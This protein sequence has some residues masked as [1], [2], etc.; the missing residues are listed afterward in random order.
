MDKM[1]KTQRTTKSK[2]SM[3]KSTATLQPY[4]HFNGRCEEAIK[5]YQAAIGA[6]VVMQMRFKEAPEQP[7]AGCLPPGF[8]NK[9]MHAEVSIGE[10]RLLLTDG[11]DGHEPGKANFHGVSLTLSVNTA[12]EA[13]RYFNGLAKDGQIQMPIGKTFFSPM[14]GMVSDRFGV[15]W[16]VYTNPAA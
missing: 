4:L 6:E 13:T 9:I 8:E 15:K 10:G 2:S 12:S 11:P 3:S 14:F 7:P 16:M 1:K 5:H